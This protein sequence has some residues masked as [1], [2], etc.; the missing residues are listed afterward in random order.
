MIVPNQTTEQST[1]LTQLGNMETDDRN[2]IQSYTYKK[3]AELTFYIQQ[4]NKEYTQ[5][6]SRLPELE[7]ELNKKVSEYEAIVDMYM[8][9]VEEVG[10]PEVTVTESKEEESE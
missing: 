1:A 2:P 4:L 5:L 7:L 6:T 8:E 10:E 9:T 3:I